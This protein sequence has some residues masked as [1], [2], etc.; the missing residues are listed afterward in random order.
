M[1]NDLNTAISI[2]MTV[3]K[4]NMQL[5]HIDKVRIMHCEVPFSLFRKTNSKKKKKNSIQNIW[6]GIL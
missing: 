4:Y 3:I 2:A 6:K 5:Y 1:N